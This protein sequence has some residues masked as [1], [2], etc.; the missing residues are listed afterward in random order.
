LRQVRTGRKPFSAKCYGLKQPARLPK[1]Q[2]DIAAMVKD[3]AYCR[4][5]LACEGEHRFPVT[6]LTPV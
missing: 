3:V 5:V 6:R 4:I 1:G 2:G